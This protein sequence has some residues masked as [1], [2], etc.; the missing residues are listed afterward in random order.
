VKRPGG[1]TKT[2]ERELPAE[3]YR[4][5]AN[6]F[7]AQYPPALRC[8]PD[9][10]GCWLNQGFPDRAFAFSADGIFHKSPL[11]RSVAGLDFS[12]PVWLRLGFINEA[13]YNWYTA[14]PDVH[15]A[16]RDR[17]FWMGWRRWHLAM[18]WYEVVR[19]PAAYAGGELCWRGE[20]LWEG[21]GEHFSRWTGDSCRTIETAD[22]GRRISASPSNRTRSPCR[23]PRRGTCAC[24]NSRARCWQS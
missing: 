18:P 14:A 3:V 21:E 1:P 15:R 20:L 19:L 10:D 2:L 17:R 8:R 22:A 5:L 4:H 24:R 13:R 12:D 23:S 6:E 9:M 16:D 7:D 11:S